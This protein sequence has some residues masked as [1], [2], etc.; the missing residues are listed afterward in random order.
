MRYLRL[1]KYK[2]KTIIIQDNCS[3]VGN[4][5]FE[6]KVILPEGIIRGSTSYNTVACCKVNAKQEIDYYLE[7]R[8]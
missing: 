4:F 6:Y 5:P 2:G 7:E 8:L 1:F 3:G